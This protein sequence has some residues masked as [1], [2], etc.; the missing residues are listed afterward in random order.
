MIDGALRANGAANLAPGAAGGSIRLDAADILGVGVV[1]ANGGPGGGG[2]RV[3]LYANALADGLVSRARAW[4]GQRT[5]AGMS[6]THQ[7]AAGTVFLKRATDLHGELVID[8]RGLVSVHW[9]DLT[10]V[11]EGIVDAV[12]T[13]SITDLEADFRSSLIGVEVYFNGDNAAS[14]PILAHAHHGASL[15]LDVAGLPLAASVGDSY[16]GRYVFDRVSVRGAA[17]ARVV[18]AVTLAE[19]AAVEPGAVWVADYEPPVLAFPD[20]EILEG[21]GD[22]TLIYLT[23]TLSRPAEENATF[24]YTAV[25]ETATAGE[26]FV[27][28]TG[29]LT[30]PFG[31]STAILP[32]RLISDALPE[33]DETL[34][35]EISAPTGLVP[36]EP[37]MRLTLRDDDGGA[38]CA[39]PELLQNGDAEEPLI[40]GLIPGWISEGSPRW[41]APAGSA[42]TGAHYFEPWASSC[43]RGLHQDVNITSFATAVDAGGLRFALSGY[44]RSLADPSPDTTEIEVEYRDSANSV[45]L[46]RATSGAVASVDAWSR[47]AALVQPPAGTRFL[48][49]RLISNGGGC[50]SRPMRGYF[51]SLSLAPFDFPSLAVGDVATV[52]GTGGLST[53]VFPVELAC[54]LGQPVTAH[55]ATVAGSATAPADFTAVEQELAFAVG[56]TQ[57]LVAIDVQTDAID[58]SDETLTLQLSSAAGAFVRRAAATGTIQDDDTATLAAGDV[59]LSEGTGGTTTAEVQVSLSTPSAQT[60]TVLAATAAGTATEPADFTTSSSTLTFASGETVKTLPVPIIPDAVDEN[61]ETLY[62][63]LSGATGAAIAD[64]EATVTIADDDDNHLTIADVALSEG[65]EAPVQMIFTVQLSSPALEGAEVQFHTEDITATAGADYQAVTSVLTIPQ[66]ASSATVVVDLVP[67]PDVEPPESFRMVVT[68]ATGV[69]LDDPEA[70]GTLLDDDLTIS[71]AD[72]AGAEGSSGVLPWIF[73]VTL[74]APAP[75]AVSVAYATAELPSGSPDRAFVPEDFSATSGTLD[76]AT[77]A[78]Q[79]AI[80]VN[81]R[82]DLIDEPLKRFLLRLSLPVNVRI[83]DG[84][85][86]GVI[87]DDE[88]PTMPGFSAPVPPGSLFD[89]G[90]PLDIRTSAADAAGIANVT[91]ELDGVQFVDTQSPYEWST[92]TPEPAGLTTYTILATALDTLGNSKTI[93]TTIRVRAPQIPPTLHPELVAIDYDFFG[94]SAIGQPG[95]VTDPTDP[96]FRIE[97]RNLRSNASRFVYAESDGSFSVLLEGLAGDNFELI[98]YDQIGLSSPTLTLGPLVGDEGRMAYLGF[99][100]DL[101][102][103]QASEIAVCRCYYM[104][105][106]PETPETGDIDL[107]LFD[108]SLP[109][110]PA[111]EG[112]LRVPLHWSWEDPCLTGAST[113]SSSCSAAAGYQPCYNDCINACPSGDTAC[114]D[115][116]SQSCGGAQYGACNAHCDAGATLCGPYEACAS[117]AAACSDSCTAAGGGVDCANA[118]AAFSNVCSSAPPA[119][120]CLTGPPAC[121]DYCYSL[122][123]I[124][125]CYSDCAATCAPE[126]YDCYNGCYLTC[127]GARMDSC[128]DPCDAGW[129]SAEAELCLSGVSCMDAAA[130]C[131]SA[132][133]AAGGDPDCSSAC[134]LFANACDSGGPTPPLFHKYPFTGFAFADG[135]AAMTQGP[136]LRVV[137]VRDRAQPVLVDADQTLQLLPEGFPTGDDLAGVRLEGGYAFTVERLTPNRFFVVDV[138]DPAHPRLLA[139]T[140]LNLGTVDGFEVEGGRLHVTKRSGS[141][142]SYRLY[143]LGEPGEIF[144]ITSSGAVTFTDSTAVALEVIDDLATFLRSSEYPG[145]EL[146]SFHGAEISEAPLVSTALPDT[147]CYQGSTAQIG[148]LFAITCGD[149]ELATGT[150]D[151]S[152]ASHGFT[153]E[154]WRQVPASSDRVS[155][156]LVA[157]GRFW[158]FPGSE[159]YASSALWPWLEESLLAVDLTADG[160]TVTGAPGSAAGA[161]FLRAWTGSGGYFEVPVAVDGAFTLALSGELRGEKVTLQAVFETDATGN[162]VRLRIPLGNPGGT[163]DLSASGG[164]RRVARDGELL[165]VV[166]AE[167][168]GGGLAHLRIASTAGGL[169]ALSEVT[170][171]GPVSDAVLLNGVLYV[172]GARLAIFDLTDPTNPLAQADVDLFAGQPLVALVLEGGRLWALGAEGGS[173]RLLPVDLSVALDPVAVPAESLLVAN[174]AESRLFARGVDL[175]RLGTARVERFDLP[176]GAPP[177]LVASGSPAGVTMTDLES[178]GGALFVAARGEGAR[179]LIE[180]TGVFTL[181]ATPS[182]AH[183]AAGL[184]VIPEAGGERLWRAAGLPGAAEVGTAK[185]SPTSCLLSDVVVSATD[186]LLVTGCGIEREVLP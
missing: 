56:E 125:P 52:E 136:L 147:S 111:L 64:N 61:D 99:G 96:P 30:I 54:A 156:L 158:T 59:T 29:T 149:Y 75:I 143:A 35:V 13:D 91:F 86:Q 66:G 37:P 55:A 164:A 176:P 100:S 88:P 135:A 39:G 170:V 43:P 3:A 173:Q 178:A 34:R 85:A 7:G 21:S 22:E 122:V 123:D 141:S 126:D 79:S 28:G 78:T 172:G 74:N 163:L 9:T 14:W 67:D 127:G 53:L 182:P 46:G 106:G 146:Y 138:H 70:I 157:N 121:T 83:I 168:D 113:C 145:T 48:R 137:D 184:F 19:P 153:L 107:R 150:L 140:S 57:K 76:F 25:G 104:P 167:L 185:H 180:T 124:E 5:G 118:C 15:T 120:G 109:L 183:A 81:V 32:L 144:A 139:T 154:R 40:G 26:D 155:K 38:H 114:Y 92:T 101:V 130:A 133:Q 73:P 103:A 80:L 58:E 24:T 45:A 10:S 27:A 84:E 72:L 49:V 177:V 162:K 60:V 110:A 102:V 41:L 119:P 23:A 20:L 11:G 161:T 132:C 116:C 174:V 134:A 160:A 1:E 62:V 50:D 117:A 77:G 68:Q 148:D 94:L 93:Q 89:G 159:G 8:N 95:A 169:A 87:L 108:A 131:S 151:T 129:N 179:A 17:K 31:G 63:R 166:P 71:I 16:A 51:D 165:A 36:A 2:G 97:V 18:D 69:S 4:G 44:V 6:S 152:L 142:L 105:Q 115:A 82:G 128:A 98:V 65:T 42:H 12:A 33:P 47:L 175:Y 90:V 186:L 112:A 181:G 171:A